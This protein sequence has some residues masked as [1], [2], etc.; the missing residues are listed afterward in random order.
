M[1]VLLFSRMAALNSD[2]PQRHVLRRGLA[3]FRRERWCYGLPQQ[4]AARKFVR[5]THMIIPASMAGCLGDRSQLSSV[6]LRLRLYS[7]SH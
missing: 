1:D 6:D 4:L 5:T 3:Q 7:S 2:E